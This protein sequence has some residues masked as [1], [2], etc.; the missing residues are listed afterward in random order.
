MLLQKYSLFS[1][2]PMALFLLIYVT[3]SVVVGDFYKVPVSAVFLLACVY[4]VVIS[5]GPLGQRLEA[6]SKGAGHPDIILM[7]WIFI[8]AGAFAGVAKDM[9]AV[10][11]T[12]QLALSVIPSKLLYAGLF[13]TACF[14]SFAVGT[15]VGTIATLAPIAAEL[16]ATCGENSAFMAAIII[17][18]AFFGDNLS[19]ISDTT[20]AASRAAGCEMK[21]KFKT[22]IIIVLPAVLI[23]TVIYLCRGWNL[24]VEA[25]MITGEWYKVLPY[26]LV[27]VL[28][29]TGKNVTFILSAG[30]VSA[31]IVGFLSGA[32][33]WIG[34]LIS[35]GNGIVGMNELIIITLLAGGMLELIHRGGGLDLIIESITKNVKSRKT[36]QFSIAILVALANLCT[37]NNTIAI[38][39][40]GGIASDISKRFGISPQKT[41][42]ILDTFS[43]FVQGLIP[44]GA[45]ILMAAGLFGI[46]PAS[47]VPVLYYPVILGIFAILSIA[48]DYPRQKNC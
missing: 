40:T 42:S 17:G 1:L 34:F 44:Y 39:T 19:F 46:S 35:V 25:S 11:A 9:G 29:L 24:S 38:I 22:N 28:A 23:V 21:D 43:C 32:F 4:A 37:A 31:A 45:Q 7:I 6:F 26:L 10:D 33:D 13:L 12:A 20:I 41:A 8:L 30:I 3:A 47:I 48:F 2:S 14:I 16:T 27:I 5:K 36:A 18:G 15:S